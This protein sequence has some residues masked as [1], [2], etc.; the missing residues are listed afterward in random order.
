MSSAVLEAGENGLSVE[1][2][3]GCDSTSKEDNEG[4]MISS[5]WTGWNIAFIGGG[6]GVMGEWGPVSKRSSKDMLGFP[7][8]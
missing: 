5:S 6:L 8:D 4:R 1:I 2:C 7:G 3:R